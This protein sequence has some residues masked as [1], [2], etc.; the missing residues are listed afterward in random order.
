MK[1]DISK[2]FDSVQW[3]FVLN[4]LLVHGFPLKFVHW[5]Q[6]CTTT[7]SFLVQV[8]GELAG[9]LQRKRGLRQGCSLYPYL[10]VICMNALS[11]RMDKAVMDKRF[12]YHPLCRRL[13]KIIEG[14]ISVF[15]GFARE[16]GLSISL[17]KST[18]YMAGV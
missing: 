2:A 1:I 18:I 3:D 4:T 14:V 17:E 7:P 5:I 11:S 16:S 15:D 10:F 13:Q 6:I 12:G 9:Y 8:N